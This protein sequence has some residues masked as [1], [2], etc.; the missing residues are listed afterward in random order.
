MFDLNK[1]VEEWRQQMA[2]GGIKPAGVLDELEGHLREDVER[3]VQA[4]TG[5]QQAF[6]LAVQRL[7]QAGALKVE[8]GRAD[9]KKAMRRFVIYTA[10]LAYVWV[11]LMGT[12]SLLNVEMSS[13]L[14]WLGF[15][16]VALLVLSLGGKQL[17]YRFLPGLP[18]R[19]VRSMVQW[20]C[21]VLAVAW[22][23]VY[24]YAVLPHVSWTI[25]QLVVATLWSFNLPPVVIGVIRGMDEAAR[26]RAAM[27]SA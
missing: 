25:G 4:G 1:A 5:P 10:V 9:R 11:M 13:R 2:A 22:L 14:R 8:F 26:R 16:A 24:G 18:N 15:G 27:V 12:Y 6:E 17:L 19:R 21:L 7:G 3:Q 23:P 20:S